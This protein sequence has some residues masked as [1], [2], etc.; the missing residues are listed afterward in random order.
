MRYGELFE[1]L[2][3]RVEKGEE[4]KEEGEQRAFGK[5]V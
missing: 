4:E 5:E 2:K 1:R 3:S